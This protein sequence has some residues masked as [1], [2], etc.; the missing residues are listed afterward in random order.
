MKDKIW[1]LVGCTILAAGSWVSGVIAGSAMKQSDLMKIVY[2]TV[3]E[4]KSKKQDEEKAETEETEEK[5]EA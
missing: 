3:L 1:T 5:E 4:N 2:T